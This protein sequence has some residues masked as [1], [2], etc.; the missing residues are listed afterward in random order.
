MPS[1][2]LL[3]FGLQFLELH[4]LL[5]EL[6]RKLLGSDL[7]RKKN[8]HDLEYQLNVKDRFLPD[9]DNCNTTFSFNIHRI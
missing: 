4:L 6:L 7:L 9:I 3:K 2:D 8:Q 1:I 5:K